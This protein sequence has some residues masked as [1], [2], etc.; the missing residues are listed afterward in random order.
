[1]WGLPGSV[2]ERKTI[3]GL[4]ASASNILVLDKVSSEVLKAGRS[5]KKTDSILGRSAHNVQPIS[6]CVSATA[7]KT[8]TTKKL[9][10]EYNLKWNLLDPILDFTVTQP[11]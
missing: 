9:V 2:G 7:I 6:G 10:Y 4:K 3:N 8:T 11:L 5:T 1:M